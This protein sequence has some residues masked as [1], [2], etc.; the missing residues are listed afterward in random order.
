VRRNLTLREAAERGTKTSRCQAPCGLTASKTVQRLSR[1]APPQNLH[2]TSHARAKPAQ[3]QAKPKTDVP[4]I[5]TIIAV[6]SGKARWQTTTQQSGARLFQATG[7]GGV[8]DADI[9]PVDASA[10]LVSPTS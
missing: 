6:A 5:S 3:P 7:Q 8:P 9:T 10:A 1:R 2:H 4:G